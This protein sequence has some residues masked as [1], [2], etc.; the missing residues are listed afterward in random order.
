MKSPSLYPAALGVC[1]TFLALSAG[2]QTATGNASP[3]ATGSS[4][5]APAASTHKHHAMAH[6]QT[7]AKHMHMGAGASGSNQ[8]EAYR[9][10]LKS[11][12]AG[13]QTQRDGCLD[14]AIARF[15]RS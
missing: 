6:H 14:D 3:A 11:C 9:S 10:A 2:A 5:M 1:L 13:P 8:D 7:H 15:G 12:V 4:T